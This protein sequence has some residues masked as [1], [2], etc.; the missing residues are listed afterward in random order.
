[1]EIIKIDH[2]ETIIDDSQIRRLLESIMFN[3]TYGKIQNIAQTI[4]AKT[5]GRFFIAKDGEHII[6]LMGF[7]KVDNHMLII[8]HFA[9]MDNSK[10][11]PV[12]KALLDYA[13][14]EE[15]VKFVTTEA[16]EA[17]TAFY[18][19]YGFKLKKLPYDDARGQLVECTFETKYK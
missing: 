15:R 8:K 12:G 10:S 3:P 6:G 19:G 17:F 9:V 14:D 7:S 16:D 2:Y 11:M 1:M 18:K 5:Q 13:I 4:Y